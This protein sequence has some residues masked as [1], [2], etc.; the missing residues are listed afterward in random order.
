MLSLFL[1]VPFDE[2]T[3]HRQEHAGQTALRLGSVLLGMV[4]LGTAVW[5]GPAVAQQTDESDATYTSSPN[6]EQ[7]GHFSASLSTV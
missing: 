6:P 7:N 2:W 4:L 5:T 3:G 1:N